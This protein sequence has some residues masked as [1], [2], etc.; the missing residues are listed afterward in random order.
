[1]IPVIDLPWFKL[2]VEDWINSTTI[3]SFTSEQEG[4]YLR[5]LIRQ[6]MANDGYLPTNPEALANWAR[7]KHTRWQKV[8]G[9]VLDQCFIHENGHYFNR[10]MRTQWEE[11][12]EVRKAKQRGGK[13]GAQRRWDDQ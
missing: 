5:L 6:W 12:R 2:F 8:G 11:A 10:K 3:A 1:M 13:L 7:V 4:I 9:P